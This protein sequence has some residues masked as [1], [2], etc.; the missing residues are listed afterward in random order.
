MSLRFLLPLSVFCCFS[1]VSFGQGQLIARG[2]RGSQQTVPKPG[3]LY[4]LPQFYGKW[5]ETKRVGNKKSVAFLDTTLLIFNENKT[6]E[7]RKTT[8]DKMALRM[9]EKASIDDENVLMSADQDYTAM[10]VTKDQIVL[11]DQDDTTHYFKKVKMFAYETAAGYVPAKDPSV[12]KQD[13]SVSIG[14]IMGNWTVYK[15]EAKPGYITSTTIVLKYLNITKK[16]DAN[17]ASG[18]ATIYSGETSQE[19]PCTILIRG[20]NIKI[21][22]ANIIYDLPVKVADGKEFDFGTTDMMYYCKQL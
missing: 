20:K 10:S 6:V 12:P 9:I 15:R 11:L 5:Q 2:H 22:T 19:V 16:I 13:V 18:T 7:T 1:A 8:D 4:S 21:S 3:T 17:N 14:N